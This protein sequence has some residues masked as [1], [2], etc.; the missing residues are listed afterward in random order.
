MFH[1]NSTLFRHTTAMQ[2]MHVA[3]MLTFKKDKWSEKK[4]LKKY[5][6]L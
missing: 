3:F 5:N 2:Q 4:C 1:F 6:F